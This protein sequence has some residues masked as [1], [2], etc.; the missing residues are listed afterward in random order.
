[1]SS[2]PGEPE[3]N[4]EK[5][6]PQEL[7]AE[8]ALMRA[9][10][11]AARVE[12]DDLRVRPPSRRR[13]RRTAA[14]ILVV[15]SCLSFLTGGVGIWANRSLLDTDV[16]VDH[17]GPLVDNPEVQAALSAKITDETMQLI[18]PKALF[19]EALPERGQVLAVPLSSAVRTFVGDAV[20]KV[21][22]SKQFETL[23]VDL[24]RQAHSAAVKVLRGDAEAVTTGNGTVTVSLVP[25]INQVLARIT[26]ASPEIFGRTV[27]IP[28]V[29]IDAVPASAIKEI[30]DALGTDLPADFG[31]I[32]FYDHGQLKELQDAISLFD[33]L[34]W[35]SVVVFVI[36][37]VGALTL[38]VNRRRTF[39][40]LAVVDV[41][42]LILMR[43]AAI[44]AQNQLLNLVKVPANTGA[45]KA[46]S[47]AILQ[48]LFDGTRILMWILAI[49]VGLV[50]VTGPSDRARSLRR[51][52]TSLAT[53]VATAARD[54]GTD[55][56][57]TVWVV[58]HRDMLRI[59]G[60]VLAVA[61]LWW[62]SMSWFWVFILL[63][64]LG[65]YEV[66]LSRLDPDYPLDGPDVERLRSLLGLPERGRRHGC[67][68][69][70][71]TARSKR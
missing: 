63:V 34:L 21:V 37:T 66:L 71:V 56:A 3:S 27:N 29:Q 43:R 36:S 10:R 9:E 65:G 69:S 51:G 60:V 30:N 68:R 48:G 52:T 54:R 23:W 13:V 1:M 20:D 15:I 42:L 31:Q 17:V 40:Q 33:T 38:S 7:Q 2:E 6:A 24:N 4:V 58:A 5:P 45:V 44:T 55:P 47:D 41:V 14:G 49:L 50:W 32:T 8:L 28:D 57:T 22:A 35:V 11:D 16:W 46:V 59:A 26:A 64:I 67:V 62:V 12:L 19:Q 70:A 18:D 61:L 53:G 25:A 39:V